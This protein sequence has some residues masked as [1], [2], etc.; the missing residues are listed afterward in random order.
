MVL[1]RIGQARHVPGA[2]RHADARATEVVADR[3]RAAAVASSR[4]R[5]SEAL[6]PTLSRKREKGYSGPLAELR[7]A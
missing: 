7:R 4:A 3:F 5:K 2:G 1:E 6:T